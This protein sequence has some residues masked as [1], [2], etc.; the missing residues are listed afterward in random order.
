MHPEMN[1]SLS[2]VPS[3]LNLLADLDI[4]AKSVDPDFVPVSDVVLFSSFDLP[5]NTSINDLSKGTL[6]YRLIS[7]ASARPSS[8]WWLDALDTVFKYYPTEMDVAPCA[9]EIYLA[10]VAQSHI[11]AGHAQLDYLE[12]KAPG[13]QFIDS[14][15][16]SVPIVFKQA[17]GEPVEPVSPA[18][19]PPASYVS[20]PPGKGPEGMIPPP[21]TGTQADY[22]ALA[23]EPVVS[24][25]TSPDSGGE[26]GYGVAGGPIEGADGTPL[27]TDTFSPGIVADTGVAKDLD[28]ALVREGRRGEEIQHDNVGAAA[29]GGMGL[30]GDE[31]IKGNDCGCDHPCPSPCGCGNEIISPELVATRKEEEDTKQGLKEDIELLTRKIEEADKWKALLDKISVVTGEQD[32]IKRIESYVHPSHPITAGHDDLEMKAGCT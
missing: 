15:E 27:T 17:H 20:V 29:M 12:G 28:G 10:R 18:S 13:I 16:E 30:S 4:L 7:D 25:P 32:T 31:E 22:D 8:E 21:A 24:T 23:S 3:S 2:S 19:T 14:N 5:M 26:E 11:E 1:H 9:A 6:V